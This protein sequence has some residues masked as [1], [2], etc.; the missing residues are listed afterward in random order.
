MYAFMQNFTIGRKREFM[1]KN[2]NRRNGK[3]AT[4]KN[5]TI[6]QFEK[7]TG[8]DQHLSGSDQELTLQSLSKQLNVI[9]EKLKKKSIIPG[10]IK[11][12]TGTIIFQILL[13]VISSY[14]QGFIGLNG[15]TDAEELR[16]LLKL[17]EKFEQFETK[18]NKLEIEFEKMQENFTDLRVDV[19]V[20]KSTINLLD[21]NLLG[22]YYN[23]TVLCYPNFGIRFKLVNREFLLEE[24]RWNSSQDIIGYIDDDINLT[25]GELFNTPILIPGEQNGKEVY[26][27]GQYNENNHWN[28]KCIINIYNDNKLEMIY[29]GVF[30]DGTLFSY[31]RVTV[32][33][34]GTWLINDRISH[35]DYNIGKTWAYRKTRDIEKSFTMD[36]VSV[37]DILDVDEF[38]E[39]LDEDIIGYYNGRTS[40]GYFN[41]DTGEAYS[42]KYFLPEQLA[43]SNGEPVIRTLYKGR[44][45]DGKYKDDTFTA[46]DITREVETKYMYFHGCFADNTANA[47][48]DDNR[49]EKKP[50]LSYEDITEIL[51]QRN[52]Y[53]DIYG[54]FLV[55]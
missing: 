52:F 27:Y 30:D 42:I 26:F 13:F 12:L 1:G 17:P 51:K 40:N 3:R 2:Y 48:L 8:I 19:L 44:F 5:K 18:L 22:R 7:S 9:E 36:N 43:G 38:L 23:K 21:N 29:E 37:E 10:W 20:M 55:D 45:V 50:E 28:G 54:E 31:K 53:E 32:E 34:E 6:N 35:E 47:G 14:F 39:S 25:A 33:P 16:S 46:W 49:E 41:D 15:E 24:P 11:W 4:G